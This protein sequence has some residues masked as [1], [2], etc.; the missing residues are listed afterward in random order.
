MRTAAIEADHTPAAAGGAERRRVRPLTLTA[1]LV[2]FAILVGLGSW[3]L[4]RLGW[5]TRLLQR[6]AALQAAKPVPLAGALTRL[7]N[8]A[9]L[10]FTRVTTQ[11]PTLE[12][13]PT[14]RLY[15]LD[16]RGMGYRLITACAVEGGAYRSILVD[17][18]FVPR[19]QADRVR[20]SRGALDAPV[21][22]V[23][24]RGDA[25]GW[26]TPK[27]TEAV[28]DWYGRDLPAMAAALQAEAP[29]P[30]FLM[31]ESPAPREFGPTPSPLPGEIRN[32]HLGYAITWFGLA[33]ALVGVY[34]A[35]LLRPRVRG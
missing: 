18:G 9:D 23:L 7:A 35:S 29:A 25:P 15:A 3:Q 21:V 30:I 16:E 17:R 2:A 24:R 19:E 11:C 26:L 1:V 8:G 28:G 20:P 13:T 22:G 5:K 31:L 14:I 33:A 6:V 27:H 34:A 4:Q 10:D 32:P 12:H